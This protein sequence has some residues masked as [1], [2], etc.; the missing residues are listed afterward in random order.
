MSTKRKRAA[1]IIGVILCALLISVLVLS[2]R[3]DVGPNLSTMATRLATI[4]NV[5]NYAWISDHEVLV[6]DSGPINRPLAAIKVRLFDAVTNRETPMKLDAVGGV[7]QIEGRIT[8]L[9]HYAPD[10]SFLIWQPENGKITEPDTFQYVSMHGGTRGYFH[11]HNETGDVYLR[12]EFMRWDGPNAF[13]FRACKR[14]E[15][16]TWRC[17]IKWSA[18]HLRLISR[19]SVPSGESVAPPSMPTTYSYF[20]HK[21]K[22]TELH[23]MANTFVQ[24]K[25]NGNSISDIHLAP[26]AHIQVSGWIEGPGNLPIEYYD[27]RRPLIE[28]LIHKVFPGYK[29]HAYPISRFGLFNTDT[30]VY[31]NIGYL[32]LETNYASR[33]NPGINP[34]IGICCGG[35]KLWFVYN[36]AIYTIQCP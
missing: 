15:V 34:D 35:K 17:E 18:P 36:D 24:G 11:I 13:L 1:S 8:P 3:D 4:S 22:P 6:W 29:R 2:G 26:D 23:V 19:A 5:D 33:A 16:E 21:A 25:V 27:P 7:V 10:R 12:Q 31:K 14:G 28:N 32:P 30:R 9:V 20:W